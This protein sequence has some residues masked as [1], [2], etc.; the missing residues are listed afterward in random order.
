M[1]N[2]NEKEINDIIF[3]AFILFACI[4]FSFCVII[5][6]LYHKDS[7]KEKNIKPEIIVQKEKV[8]EVYASRIG[9]IGN[10]TF[11]GLVV[12]PDSTFVA[13]PSRNVQKKYVKVS[14]KKSYAICQVLD[15]GPWSRND[16]YWETGKKPKAENKIADYNINNGVNK[17]MA[18]IDLSDGLWKKLGIKRGLGIVKV[19]W[20]FIREPNISDNNIIACI[21]D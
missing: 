7:I 20:C 2:I 9:L 13:L 17:N 8:H 16:P 14:Y 21:N 11:S 4:I 19:K 3:S 1:N 12:K 18:G 5:I 15:L 10:T 6:F